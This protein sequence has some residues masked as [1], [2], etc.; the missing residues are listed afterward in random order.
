MQI[1]CKKETTKRL[2]LESIQGHQQDKK[3]EQLNKM[4]NLRCILTIKR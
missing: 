1:S 3:K 4:D 2:S